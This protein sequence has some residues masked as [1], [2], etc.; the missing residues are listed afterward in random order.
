[1]SDSQPTQ[2]CAVNDIL[3]GK[4]KVQSIPTKTT[5][6][7]GK[8]AYGYVCYCI[9]I[10]TGM[11]CAVKSEARSSAD[12]GDILRFIDISRGIEHPNIVTLL[13]FDVTINEEYDFVLTTVYPIY[14]SK[15]TITDTSKMDSIMFQ[16][17]EAL[18]YLEKNR[19]LHNDIKPDNLLWTPEGSP[20]LIDLGISKR[21]QT[22]KMLS[23]I[24]VVTS[25]Y[26][27]PAAIMLIPLD[28]R[29]D[30][31]SVGATLIE[32]LV[33]N[34]MIAYDMR[35]QY[36]RFLRDDNLYNETV[37][38]GITVDWDQICSF[39]PPI[40]DR[41][42]VSDNVKATL[43]TMLNP[44]NTSTAEELLKSFTSASTSMMA[45][46]IIPIS[47]P[48]YLNPIAPEHIEYI[49]SNIKRLDGIISLMTSGYYNLTII[50]YYVIHMIQFFHYYCIN[51]ASAV[52]D[53]V[54]LELEDPYS[55]NYALDIHDSL[56]MSIKVR[57]EALALVKHLNY[58]YHFKTLFDFDPTINL[59]KY[60]N[61]VM[62]GAIMSLT[63]DEAL[64]ELKK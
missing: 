60:Y 41:L 57:K 15:K 33:G 29:S 32:L 48:I 62:S 17:L 34:Y 3:L 45:T 55:S 46:P 58:T 20:V 28:S 1:M 2:K 11:K 52:S 61:L 53:M 43:K 23:I 63:Y 14:E 22:D 51:R 30:Q 9:D 19:I 16:L 35:G 36:T 49:N 64:Q 50:K 27:S 4:Y 8:G 25:Y 24:P 39:I 18:Y 54:F 56:S 47:Y 13:D 42:R 7:L 26:R 37:N 6:L 40:I 21:Y 31:W 59:D 38:N 10:T 12:L 44:S 5:G